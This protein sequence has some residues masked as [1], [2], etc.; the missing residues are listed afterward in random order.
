MD[1]KTQ[2]E[3]LELI[4][5]ISQSLAQKKDKQADFKQ[6]QEML[7]DLEKHHHCILVY[8]K[9]ILQKKI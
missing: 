5:E 1:L 9:S 2:K 6:E 3:A 4:L 8:P 7:K